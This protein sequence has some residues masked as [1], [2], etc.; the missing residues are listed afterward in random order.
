M[1][2]KILH[3]KKPAFSEDKIRDMLD[4]VEGEIF[5]RG[6][7]QESIEKN[8]KKPTTIRATSFQSCHQ[9]RNLMKLRALS[10]L[11]WI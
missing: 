3:A 9:F 1:T 10:T 8:S 11:Q 7:F 6:R 4:P 2:I 5:D